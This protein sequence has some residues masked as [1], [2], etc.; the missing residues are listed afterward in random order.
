VVFPSEESLLKAEQKLKENHILPRRY[1]YPS[2]NKLPYVTY[3]KMPV[4]EDISSRVL[5]LPL[6]TEVTNEQVEKISS[7]IKKCL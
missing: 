3:E 6:S 7:I 5:C 2:L 4:A 1:F